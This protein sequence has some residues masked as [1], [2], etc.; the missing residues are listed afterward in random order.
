MDLFYLIL[1]FV[2]IILAFI[3]C[4]LPIIPGP[5]TGWFSFIFLYQIDGVKINNTLLLIT[6][7]VS[8]LVFLVD[9]LLPI[10]GTKVFGGSK[11]G[12]F[13]ASI[14]LIIGVLS[15]GPLGLVI[16]P[17]F[18]AFIGELL[19]DNR[20]IR[21]AIKASIGTI[22]GLLSGFFLKFT[23]TSLFLIIYLF[24]VW[25]FRFTIF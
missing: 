10:L 23:V 22:L 4:F 13:G 19:N 3:G 1:S 20:K 24:E 7:I 5:L 15:F 14:G 2:T 6:F 9:Y 17:I 21:I 16:G 8:I 12:I 25:K 18:G 11:K